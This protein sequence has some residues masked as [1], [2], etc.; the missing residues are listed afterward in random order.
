MKKKDI[1]VLVI[2]VLKEVQQMSGREWTTLGDDAPPIGTLEGFDSLAGM[3]ATA[4]IEEKLKA[5]AGLNLL[6]DESVFV[7]EN[8]ALT[9]SQICDKISA[10]LAGDA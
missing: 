4:L 10:V 2:S 7:A 3:E 8:K 9:L 1:Q 5:A 6:G